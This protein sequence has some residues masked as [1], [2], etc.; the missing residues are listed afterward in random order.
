[1]TKS[2]PAREPARR[3]MP[4]PPS[5]PSDKKEKSGA[6]SP[7]VSPIPD[8]ENSFPSS[9]SSPAAATFDF[10]NVDWSGGSSSTIDDELP[11]FSEKIELPTVA[12]QSRRGF[13]GKLS[14]NRKMRTLQAVP[15][16]RAKSITESST[17]PRGDKK[18]KKINVADISGPVVSELSSCEIY[19]HLIENFSLRNV[20]FMFLYCTMHGYI[21]T[22]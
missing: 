5:P 17:L 12:T 14:G 11:K 6:A 19:E 1:M 10:T 8:T 3:S 15:V 16:K 20:F 9:P 2:D 13:L 7:S 21:Y 22:D 18:G 4:V